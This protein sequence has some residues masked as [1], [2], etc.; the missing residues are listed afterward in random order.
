MNQCLPVPYYADVAPYIVEF[1]CELSGRYVL[2]RQG[3]FD[4]RL[5]LCEVQVFAANS[6]P[7]RTGVNAFSVSLAGQCENG[8]LGDVCQLAC[9][10]GTFPVAGSQTSRCQGDT[11]D[12]PPLVCQAPCDNFPI[13]LA[14][15][16]I[17]TA[18]FADSFNGPFDTIHSVW[19]PLANQQANWDT[20]WAVANGALQAMGSKSCL[21]DISLIATSVAVQANRAPYQVHALVSTAGRAGVIFDATPGTTTATSY[22]YLIDIHARTAYFQLIRQDYVT[23]LMYV[24]DLPLI[25]NAVYELEV[26]VQ[27]AA[28]TFYLNGT[29]IMYAVDSTLAAGYVG[30]YAE[31]TAV[32]D[33]VWYKIS[34]STS[35]GSVTD[36]H[37]CE[38]TCAPGYIPTGNLS[39]TCLN[40]DQGTYNPPPTWNYPVG[41]CAL[42]TPVLSNFS[43]YV[44]ES[45]PQLP[46]SLQSLCSQHGTLVGG[47]IGGQSQVEDQTLL[48]TIVGGN[49]A[50]INNVTYTNVFSISSCSGQLSVR[51]PAGLNAAAWPTF[52][53]KVQVAYADAALS[54]S[55]FGYV[56]VDVL[57]VAGPPVITTNQ[58]F[59]VAE[60]AAN[61]TIVGTI[62]STGG[63]AGA[64]Y[65]WSIASDTASGRFVINPA[66]GRV[67][68]APNN[69]QPL[70]YISQNSYTLNVQ[71]VI[72]SAPL[73]VST[74]TITIKLTEINKPPVYT[75]ATLTGNDTSVIQNYVF[76]PP[77]VP[78]FFVE[79][80]T[81]ASGFN[82]TPVVTLL[83]PAQ[84]AIT[85]GITDPN[86]IPS[87]DGKPTGAPLFGISTAGVAQSLQLIAP[88]PSW[89]TLTPPVFTYG[90]FLVRKHYEVCFNF[91][92]VGATTCS[93]AAPCHASL[94]VAILANLV[95]EPVIT[96]I[97]LYN[98]VT[99]ATVPTMA[100]AGGT[101][102]DF[103]F[104]GVL[105]T[106]GAVTAT[107]SNCGG[108]T[109][110]TIAPFGCTTYTSPKCA[111]NVTANRVRCIAAPGVGTGH[112][113]SVSY[114]GLAYP[115]AAS[116]LTSYAP[117][118]VTALS[119]NAA[120]STDGTAIVSIVGTNLGP[121]VAAAPT[122]T[123]RY[124]NAFEYFCNQVAP[125]NATQNPQLAFRCM[126]AQGAGAG[127]PF[128]LWV[129]NQ[130]VDSTSLLG[131]VTNPSFNYAP[132]TIANVSLSTT[133]QPPPANATNL[134][135][136][137]TAATLPA[138]G[139]T[140]VYIFGDNFG[141]PSS[142]APANTP[143]TISV[144]YGLVG[145]EL[146]MTNCARLAGP[147]Y[148][149]L[150]CVTAPGSGV[151][152]RLRV[153]AAG[154]PS[155]NATSGATSKMQG[156]SYAPPYVVSLAGPGVSGGPTTGGELLE[157]FAF[158][159]GPIGP[160]PASAVTYGRP[161][162][163]RYAPSCA[164][165]VASSTT[166]GQID[167][168]TTEGT[169]SGLVV[170]LNIGGQASALYSATTISYGAPVISSFARI[171]AT[172]SVQSFA[173][174]GGDVVIISGS[175]FG[176]ANG[177]A[178]LLL[179][180]ENT[181]R[182]PT[183]PALTLTATNCAVIA[184]HTQIQCL[185]AAGAGTNLEW[186]ATVDGVASTF[187]T[188]GYAKPVV[189]N[190]TDIVDVYSLAS[191]LQYSSSLN[192]NVMYNVSLLGSSFGS[193]AFGNAST[194]LITAIT[195]GP[196][197]VE[198]AANS[199][200]HIDDSHLV[201][202]VGP[203]AGAGLYFRV[204]V[205]G[206]TASSPGVT[207]GYA[208]PMITSLSFNHGP[209]ANPPGSAT[210]TQVTALNVPLLDASGALTV[211]T[212]D[213]GVVSTPLTAILPRTFT[214]VQSTWTQVGPTV[215]SANFA[216]QLPA[217][218]TG[219]GLVMRLGVVS[220]GGLSIV[221]SPLAA[222]AAVFN[223]DAPVISTAYALP[224]SF[225]PYGTPVSA[226]TS[227]LV[228]P[229]P[230]ATG[231]NPVW[232]CDGSRGTLY[233]LV[234][235]GKNFGASPLD[236]NRGPSIGHLDV[237]PSLNGTTATLWGEAGWVPKLGG[238]AGVGPGGV[239][240]APAVI[241]SWSDSRIL[242][243][244]YADVGLVDVRLT[245]LDYT[246]ALVNVTSSPSTA[247]TPNAPAVTNVTGP[248][249]NV[250]T[251]GGT[252]SAPLTMLIAGLQTGQNQIISIKV[253][254]ATC[255][256]IK[257]DGTPLIGSQD[258]YF[259]P[260][261]GPT[262]FR[263]IIPEGQ[264]AN[265]PI[266]VTLSMGPYSVATIAGDVSYAPPVVTSYSSW[267]PWNTPAWV[268]YP[269]T[270]VV[271]P[272]NRPVVFGATNGTFIN[273]YGNNL[274]T[275]P[276]L[277]LSAGPLVNAEGVP[278]KLTITIGSPASCGV[279]PQACWQFLLPE[280]QGDGRYW[281]GGADYELTLSA[282]NQA[283]SATAANFGY[284][285]PVVTSVVASSSGVPGCT[286]PTAGVCPGS[287]APITLTITGRHFGKNIAQFGETDA[288]VGPR[289]S[290][291]RS[292]EGFSTHFNCKD[293][294]RQSHFQMTCTLPAGSGA[295]L[296]VEVGLS[297]LFASGWYGGSLP[298]FSYDPPVI[299]EAYAAVRAIT[300]PSIPCYYATYEY[301]DNNANQT[302]T[303]QTL[304]CPPTP[305]SLSAMAPAAVNPRAVSFN[306]SASWHS[307]TGGAA[308]GGVLPALS[309]PSHTSI[310][311]TGQTTP[312]YLTYITLY[313]TNFGDASAVH[314]PRMAWAY[315]TA[316]NM[317]PVCNSVE[318]FLGEGEVAN[319]VSW[320]N[321][322]V[323]FVVPAGLGVKEVDLNVRGNSVRSSATLAVAGIAPPIFTYDAP[324]IS[325]MVAPLLDTNG[326]T[327]VTLTGYNFGPVPRQ[328]GA[329][330]QAILASTFSVPLTLSP[331]L[332]TTA[333]RIEFAPNVNTGPLC[334]SSALLLNG[335][336]SPYV[337]SSDYG[338][339]QPATTSAVTVSPD[340]LSLTFVAPFGV[341]AVQK[342]R[343]VIIDGPL[344]DPTYT[345]RSDTRFTAI[346]SNVFNVS[347]EP[348]IITGPLSP[349]SLINGSYTGTT[350]PLMILGFQF[351][352]PSIRNV[353]V[354]TIG[355]TVY[356]HNWTN[357]DSALSVNVGAIPCLNPTRGQVG[358]S[359]QSSISCIPDPARSIVG[360][361]NI[362]V[363]VAGQTAIVDTNTVLSRQLVTACGPN[364]FGRPGEPCAY[365]APPALPLMQVTAV[366]GT[367]GTPSVVCNGFMPPS[368]FT[369]ALDYTCYMNAL[370]LQKLAQLPPLTQAQ[371][372][373]F[374]TFSGNALQVMDL[375]SIS[376]A[377]NIAKQ[378]NGISTPVCP[379]FPYPSPQSGY[380]NLNGSMASECPPGLS[381]PNHAAPYDL[382][383]VPCLDGMCGAD[384]ICM[385]GYASLP[386]HY[387]C[388]SCAPAGYSGPGSPAYYWRGGVCVSCP[389]GYQA[390]IV[391]YIVGVA[392]VALAAY[393]FQK[394]SI[395]IGVAAIGI[396]FFQVVATMGATKVN[397]PS[398]LNT[399]LLVL[400]ASYA[401]VEI[402]APECLDPSATF[403]TKFTGIILIPAALVGLVMIVHAAAL[404]S[405][406]LVL[407]RKNEV[408][409]HSHVLVAC[410]LVLMYYLYI[411]ETATMLAVFNCAPL[412]PSD[413][414]NYMAAAPLEV[415][416]TSADGVYS[417]LLGPSI[418]GLIAY[419][420]GYPLLAAGLLLRH[421]Q[422]F[423][424][425]QLL[426]AKGVGDDRLT[427]PHAYELRKRYSVLYSHFTPDTFYWVLVILARKMLIVLVPVIFNHNA[428]FQMAAILV[429]LLCAYGLHL[430]NLPYLS[431]ANHESVLRQHVESSYTSPIHA[432]IR[433]SIAGIESRGRKRTRR[434]LIDGSGQIDRSALLGFLTS[435]LFDPNTLEGAL[436]FA[437]AI[438][439]LMGIMFE[440]EALQT[441][442]YGAS[443][444]STCSVP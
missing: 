317:V 296:V 380:F 314:C 59:Y 251:L 426:R 247:F 135:G 134:T 370:Q 24:Y 364:F 107:Y 297:D 369:V 14:V 289:I 226:G 97:G 40:N 149:T 126:A 161:G 74:G 116:L 214:D 79:P 415:C 4:A 207:F 53:L 76:S 196:T 28:F 339:C 61:N 212:L 165:V 82:G 367:P 113:W 169:G 356:S 301:Y 211:V 205:A 287:S 405:K 400:S 436:L 379:Q 133:P 305:P 29:N 276:T 344:N 355:N 102:V 120:M 428:S 243:Y 72:A 204:T 54:L 183:D 349:Y 361:S 295:N 397:W 122:T 421:R 250:S 298:G 424:E 195:Y 333:M 88:T 378:Y 203:A 170:Q 143:L 290:F 114:G 286:V 252:S 270:G 256:L 341:G 112:L 131:T 294:K 198:Y 98:N 32:F 275:S 81:P 403:A 345:N 83:S 440:S 334:A 42:P 374:A 271:D 225:L 262:T 222:P 146:I 164:V 292:A 99:L 86:V 394:N 178:P 90:S 80:N 152:L 52:L 141:P 43:L 216:V 398:Q 357:F 332:P 58:T 12:S 63:T 73:A 260:G 168:Y 23:V 393:L 117:P 437:A 234:L 340:G 315:R 273:V 21:G 103:S 242:A 18:L 31:T 77:L 335:V 209:C 13:P 187:P 434:N 217:A 352:P 191:V 127:L 241:Q 246:G 101:L 264:G 56:L 132:P 171:P 316:K 151:N 306:I 213:N 244:T 319:I 258:A 412:T 359:G 6:C 3:R 326:G 39:L 342:G 60:F 328:T 215:Y 441:S 351:G 26:D 16:G 179:T 303:N 8:I 33:D 312:T 375:S 282:G 402:V 219:Q 115:V 157:I 218:W 240:N 224:A 255:P 7:K 267:H 362:T 395:H 206:Q 277:T 444:A 423:M 245:N 199:W 105:V 416:S 358:T 57:P 41:S 37:T 427:N 93:L 304:V 87:V 313:G 365:C 45:C 353:S 399:L 145:T 249:F 409:R 236:A 320:T 139:G 17:R 121:Y 354:V 71:V 155:L 78:T 266:V 363:V 381:Y 232:T 302:L 371:L 137:V 238:A 200:T 35:C 337:L 34:S 422:V 159:T 163:M 148:K 128:R 321:T 119:G 2:I 220:A 322:K 94:H 330:G 44:S 110:A 230:W 265:N 392:L 108:I 106:T 338:V 5:Q 180:Y 323:V 1:D 391:A 404:F 401:N 19:M 95:N 274:G 309:G 10:P 176:P 182:L 235:V 386:P 239:G 221:K 385:P 417:Q 254:N 291:Y 420:A 175:N 46:K 89:F 136:V 284:N 208:P 96:A 377:L 229:C 373:Q 153:N 268:V 66:T 280:G 293:V 210:T 430:R 70:S 158:G 140:T 429:V 408:N 360:V 278:S 189:T 253:A 228:L 20:Y 9:A 413:G 64:T 279:T 387:R 389:S 327:L 184:A 410:V 372:K 382:C 288:L 336:P 396:D 281:T 174:S 172:S 263:C 197:G 109:N 383:L 269:A 425:D 194:D 154:T 118:T 65:V 190:I 348:P 237:R 435:W 223:Y 162:S 350:D 38:L 51:L 432:R 318:S 439:A 248:L 346:V 406:M 300:F 147:P 443:L 285:V 442:Y 368:N 124:G 150:S 418:I 366:P 75:G 173:T 84:G 188:T 62:A 167:C 307:V 407:R 22:R 50:T 49:S 15:V 325:P 310:V 431:A 308:V 414:L 160:L 331:S 259:A 156:L 433:A 283:A 257:S 100:T 11:W 27:G 192:P 411:Y 384:N 233:M 299:T 261:G 30:V 138:S 311:L 48:Y 47:P 68:V 347:Y 376:S 227:S 202:S 69:T 231:S 67:S 25:S 85:C 144:T 36:G 104:S 125:V 193:A 123:V 91:Y 130:Y 129:G 438:V 111:F 419:T 272:T 55:S 185:V 92:E 329:A 390:I 181:A 343:V 388:S 142:P 177:L 186:L 201:V 166:A 324:V